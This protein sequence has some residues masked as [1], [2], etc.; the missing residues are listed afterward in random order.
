MNAD[1]G[2]SFLTLLGAAVGCATLCYYLKLPTILGFILS[3]IAVGP[4]GLQIFDSMPEAQV[5][6]EI[7]ITLLLFTIGLEFSWTKLKRLKTYFLGLGCGQVLLTA[8]LIGCAF[9]AFTDFPLS[10]AIFIG[11]IFSL[12]STAI[13]MKILQERRETTSPYG[14][15]SIAVLLTQDLAVIPMMLALPL[16]ASGTAATGEIAPRDMVMGL[17]RFGGVLTAIFLASR[18]VFPFI[19][20]RVIRT[21]ARELFFFATLILCFGVALAIHQVGFPLSLGAFLAGLMISESHFGRQAASLI[22]PVR[23]TLLGLVF[24][25]VGMLLDIGEMLAHIG[26]VASLT[27]SVVL[28]KSL[29]IYGLCR[30]IS[31]PHRTAIKTAALLFQV[32]EFSFILAETSFSEGLLSRMELQ[33]FVAVSIFT[34]ILTPFGVTLVDRWLKSA[35]RRSSASSAAREGRDQESDDDQA[36]AIVIGY[37][38]A[39]KGIVSTLK[40]LGMPYLVIEHNIRT[41]KREAAKGE[42]IVFGDASHPEILED[43]H[44]DKARLVVVAVS[45]MGVVD[46]IVM[47]IRSL[48]KDVPIVVRLQYSRQWPQFRAMANVH[49][50]VAEYETSLSLLHQTLMT[51]GLSEME[52]K[53]WRKQLRSDFEGSSGYLLGDESVVAISSSDDNQAKAGSQPPTDRPPT[54]VNSLK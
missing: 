3:G 32:G 30:M 2:L 9:Y 24:A 25:S 23:D 4:S 34:M 13:V 17:V 48:A 39:G 31:I 12:S 43:I 1:L 54:T 41:V 53:K 6:T 22:V 33:V 8:V 14:T 47:M 21:G 36:R 52:V 20:E 29:V 38:V 37:G 18:W 40:A 11:C 51:V 50:V 19:M 15:A 7:A 44:V 46:D 35:H 27:V 45:G 16:I 10:K 5:M 49:P 42:P 28:V 26:Q